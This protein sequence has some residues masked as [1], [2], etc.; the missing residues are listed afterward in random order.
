MFAHKIEAVLAEDGT[1]TLRGL[2]FHA[3]DAVEVIILET[4]TPQQTVALPSQPEANLYPLRGK[5]VRYDDPTEP[6]ALED[7]EVLQ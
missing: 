6:V 2:P 3:G 4:Q 7:W 1:L 5:V